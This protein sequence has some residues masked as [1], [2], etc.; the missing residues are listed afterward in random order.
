MSGINAHPPPFSTTTQW[1][2]RT[3]FLTAVG[4][5]ELV[6]APQLESLLSEALEK[7]PE[8][9]VLD[10][11]QVT[12]LSSAGLATLVRTNRNA[13]QTDTRFRVIADNPATLRPIQLMGLDLEIEVID[14]QQATIDT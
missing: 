5:V 12:F 4:E 6:N 10:L 7:R 9:I 14:R 11:G 1:S 8:T 13:E 3:F 2:G